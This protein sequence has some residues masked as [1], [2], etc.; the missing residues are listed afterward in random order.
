MFLSVL[1]DVDI[2]LGL[3]GIDLGHRTLTHSIIIWSIVGGAI[4]FLISLMYKRGSENGNL[5]DSLHVAPCDRGYYSRI[6]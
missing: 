2:I 4:V 1:P 5:F 6:H 3:A